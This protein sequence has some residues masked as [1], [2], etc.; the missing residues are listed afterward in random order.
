MS[1]SLIGVCQFTVNYNLEHPEKWLPQVQNILIGV[2][3]SGPVFTK[4][5]I[6]RIVLF[7]EFFL[8][9]CNFH[10]MILRIRMFKIWNVLK[11]PQFCPV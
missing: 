1:G 9:F 4:I 10:R 5:L 7:L 2:G 8:E 6:L 3:W 11:A